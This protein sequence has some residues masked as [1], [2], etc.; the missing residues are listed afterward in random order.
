MADIIFHNFITQCGNKEVDWE[1]DT[2]KAALISGSYTPDADHT[3]YADVS[4]FELPT[5][6]GYTVGGMDVSGATCT[7]VD[8]SNRTKYDIS[9]Y[10]WTASGGGS[11]GKARYAVIYD[12]TASNYLAHLFD[13]GTDKTAVDGTAFRIKV[14][15]T[16]GLFYG[17][18]A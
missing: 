3:T 17:S 6:Y 8:A 12:S 13:F 7:N 2:L 10:F 14:D 9:N 18:Q 5:G 16:N 11:I 1:A 4:G 15:S